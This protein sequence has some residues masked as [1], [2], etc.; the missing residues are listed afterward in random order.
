MPEPLR[1]ETSFQD[2][3]GEGHY[4]VLFYKGRPLSEQLEE[5][6]LK[7]GDTILLWEEDCGGYT[8]EATL[9]VDFLHPA[10]SERKLWA[11]SLQ[12]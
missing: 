1:V 8:L 7:D 9:L 10:Y 12:P 4:F 3:D 6:G 2:T 11:R 5:L